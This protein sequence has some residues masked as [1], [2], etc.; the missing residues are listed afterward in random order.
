MPAIIDQMQRVAQI[1]RRCPEPTLVQAY[2]DAARKFCLESRWLRRESVFALAADT[3]QYELT[4][5][6]GDEGLEIIGVRLVTCA[7][8]QSSWPVGAS[9]PTG[10]N[11]NL[12]PSRPQRYA[13][14]P[15][16]QIALNPTPD[17]VYTATTT[18]QVQPTIDTDDLPDDLLRKW[19]RAL[20]DGAIAYL[21]TIGGQAWT[22]AAGAVM[23]A[24]NF[25]AQI[26]NAKAD[27]Q[28]SYNTGSV[29]AR[30][31]RMF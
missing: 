24:R 23:Y 1:V 20:A 9:D 7:D 17:G 8:D 27:E 3:P 14:V 28:R 13:Y 22:D 10:W 6:T 18:V 5:P 21:K 2:R 25:Q 29:V 15:E 12:R 11:T 26:N 16:S 30:I 31:R 19:D 4:L